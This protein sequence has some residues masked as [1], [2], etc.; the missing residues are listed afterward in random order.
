MLFVLYGPQFAFPPIRCGKHEKGCTVFQWC[1]LFPIRFIRVEPSG[2][3]GGRISDG[4]ILPYCRSGDL[5]FYLVTDSSPTQCYKQG[6]RPRVLHDPASWQRLLRSL[7]IALVFDDI[8]SGLW[9]DP[10]G[11]RWGTPPGSYNTS[12]RSTT[13]PP[14]SYNTCTHSTILPPISYAISSII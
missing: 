7:S 5:R 12:T 3:E 10:G 4:F 14:I 11:L 8:V 2:L 1:Y 13:L 6:R 9:S